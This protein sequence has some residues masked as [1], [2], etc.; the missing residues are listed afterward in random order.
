MFPKDPKVVC[1]RGLFSALDVLKRAK[2]RLKKKKKKDMPKETIK[3]GNVE[4]NPTF[5]LYRLSE[6]GTVF[7]L[8]K[9]FLSGLGAIT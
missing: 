9:L 4:E 5:F 2:Q 6:R 3:P 7:S 8:K 1:G